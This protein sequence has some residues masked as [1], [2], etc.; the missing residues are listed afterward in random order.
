[1]PQARTYM[2]AIL[3]RLEVLRHVIALQDADDII[4]QA[5]KLK[6]ANES[7]PEKDIAGEIDAI[8]KLVDN[9]AY[10]DAM[11]KISELLQRF[12]TISKW[13]DPE[14]QGLQAEIRALAAQIS[15]LEGELG[16]I[17]KTIHEFEVR[18]TQEL[19]EVVLKILSIKSRLAANNATQ[20][21]GNDKAKEEYKQAQTEEEEYKGTY[22]ETLANPIPQ[23]DEEQQKELKTKF[24]KITKLTHPDL[25]DKQFEKQATE[26]F[27][28][29]KHAQEKNDLSTLTEILDYLETGKPFKLKDE[30]LT[31]SIALRTEAKRLR[32][33]A[34]QLTQKITAI[35]TSETYQTIPQTEDWNTY[36]SDIKT[37]LE[38]ELKTLERMIKNE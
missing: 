29:A 4:Y 38:G 14:I 22:K 1:M 33:V 20:Q 17:E 12:N 23:L 37:K 21:P 10:G 6:K 8:L 9:K 35:K 5:G 2:E 19:G 34:E 26:L 27:I 32:H 28:K 24:R 7:A 18:H 13:T 31:E 11:H 30:T 15:S 3:K 25:V 16:D 36:F